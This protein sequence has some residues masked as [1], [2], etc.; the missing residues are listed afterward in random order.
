[1][2][3]LYLRLYL[4]ILYIYIFVNGLWWTVCCTAPPCSVYMHT[5]DYEEEPLLL[6]MNISETWQ[7][8]N[9]DDGFVSIKNYTLIRSDRL[10]ME[11]GVVKK[12]GGLCT[13]VKDGLVCEDMKDMIIS[14][15]DIELH[16][17]KYALPYTRPIFIFNIY[18]PPSGDIDIFINSLKLILEVYRNQKCDIFI[19]GDL[20][21]DMKHMNSQDSKKLNKFLKLSQLKQKIDKVTRPD[22]NAILDLII[23]NC[24][25]VKECS[26]LDINVSDHLPVYLIR[27]KVKS[28]NEKVDFKGRSYK[29][30]NKDIV[31]NMLR[32]VDWTTFANS[33]VDSCWNYLLENI[34]DI[35][36]NICPE[37]DFKFAKNRP[38]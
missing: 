25:I 34:M 10:T 6:N 11:A 38:S 7:H 35:L 19:G 37:K 20:N 2:Y 29:N 23:T 1:M 3:Y 8:D 15:K 9:I 32:N 21:I 16:L 28:S 5:W 17:V 24:D 4:F 22:S 14:N 13:Y 30:L 18:R 36:E 27:K 33:D 26:T 31:E 12:G